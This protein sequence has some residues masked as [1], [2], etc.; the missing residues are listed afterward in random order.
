MALL[1]PGAHFG[2]YR[3]LE[4]LGRGGMATVYK[5]YEATLDRDVALKVL[6][7][8]FVEDPGFATRFEREAR[9]IA[10][11]EHPNIV[12]IFAF[13]I[14]PQLRIPWMAM[15]LLG[16]G[17]ASSLLRQRRPTV[18]EALAVVR[19][20]ATALDHA[21]ARGVV[22][23][24][25]KPQNILLDAEGRVYL[26][27]FGIARLAE[28]ATRVTQT[29]MI[30]G[31]P[32]YMAPEQATGQPADHRAD[33]YALGVVAYELL[34]GRVP[35]SAD[36]PVAV[37][38]KH[39]SDPIPLPS[40]ADVPEPVIRALLKCLAKRPD[41][42]WGTASEFA[43]ALERGVAA[44]PAAKTMAAPAPLDVRPVR[45]RPSVPA[46]S[47]RWTVPLFAGGAGVAALLLVL[48]A[49]R[50]AQPVPSPAVTHE[51]AAPPAESTPPPLVAPAHRPAPLPA[52]SPVK[53]AAPPAP[54]VVPLA[55]SPPPPPEPTPAPAPARLDVSLEVLQD[56]RSEWAAPVLHARVALDGEVLRVLTLD[57]RGAT[58]AQETI[59]VDAPTAG[60]HRLAVAVSTGPDFTG[61][62]T[63]QGSKE[64]A[65]G[66][67]AGA[68][69]IRV[70]FVGPDDWT[71]RFAQR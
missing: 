49:G 32:N 24:D 61:E 16:G 4:P 33:V 8:E 55:Q 39:V 42:R 13:G 3:I 27:D 9:V 25:V 66:G 50:R 56:A 59:A 53:R 47:R 18:A 15:R 63:V 40:P 1:H 51:R 58:R 37:L 54:P 41:E 23:R 69:A 68:V 35:F 57:F 65:F 29:G 45:H 26:A 6:P 67:G 17:T 46:S 7:G 28:G 60:Q 62:R 31:T 12:P 48:A 43:T 11:L 36:T 2:P 30:T 70:A 71:I 34:T 38:M 64:M 10:R 52:F 19:G 44:S 21:H 5:A 20:T 14:E 22:H